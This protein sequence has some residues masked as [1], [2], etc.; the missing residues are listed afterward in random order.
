MRVTSKD[1]SGK[2]AQGESV[3][4]GLLVANSDQTGETTETT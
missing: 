2:Q 3:W 1:E 4:S